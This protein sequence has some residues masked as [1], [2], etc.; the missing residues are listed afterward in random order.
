M[1]VCK[2]YKFDVKFCRICV[3]DDNDAPRTFIWVQCILELISIT[4]LEIIEKPNVESSR[5][6][7]LCGRYKRIL[8]IG[9]ALLIGLNLIVEIIFAIMLLLSHV[10]DTSG[11]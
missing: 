8:L 3:S 10:Q 9:A 4:F 1:C 2:V 11:L 6:W 7:S 5:R